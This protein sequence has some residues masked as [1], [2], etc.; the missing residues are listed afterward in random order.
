MDC[1]NKMIRGKAGI[2][3]LLSVVSLISI[4]FGAQLIF[5]YSESNVDYDIFLE[6]FDQS[7]G[8]L[9]AD[10]IIKVTNNNNF[11]IEIRN[12]QLALYDPTKTEPFFTGDHVGATIDSLGVF[13]ESIT[14]TALYSDIPDYEVRVVFSAYLTWNGEGSHVDRDFIY[15]LEL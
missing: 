4:F 2:L 13:S 3:S 14:F 7:G 9:K 11:T 15:P 5:H 6:S 1:G 10:I 8:V 12:I